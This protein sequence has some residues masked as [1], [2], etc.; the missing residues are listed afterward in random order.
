MLLLSV[1]LEKMDAMTSSDT[2]WQSQYSDMKDI[3]EADELKVPECGESFMTLMVT[4]TGIHLCTYMF[5]VVV[6]LKRRCH[7]Y[8]MVAKV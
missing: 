2:A 1:A 3:A 4:I 8:E 6:F 5:F 7:A